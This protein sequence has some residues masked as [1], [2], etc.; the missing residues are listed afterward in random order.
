MN[1]NKIIGLG[2]SRTGT[3]SLGLAL[4][5]LG[6]KTI[7]FPIQIYSKNDLSLYSQYDA[8]V[9]LPIPLY[10]KD[11]DKMFP[12]S[13]F[14]L[15]IRDEQAWLES[16]KWLFETGKILWK[17]G[18]VLDQLHRDI[19]ETDVFD[20]KT[21]S[22][23]YRKYNNEVVEYF[24]NRENDLL[25]LDLNNGD[26]NYHKL[27]SFLNTPIL[28]E[29]FPKSNEKRKLTIWDRID[30]WGWKNIKLYRIIRYYILKIK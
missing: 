16:M 29:P 30:Y 14:I 13:K 2:L 25:I 24:K 4:E 3:T 18:A 15:T 8:F 21:L 11:I 17:H 6:F 22:F 10:Y 19:Y 5:K 7:H 26:L 1:A 9:D 27:C 20:V 12:N 28:N 23:I